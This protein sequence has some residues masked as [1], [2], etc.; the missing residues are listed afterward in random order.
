VHI[1]GGLANS[2]EMKKARA[3]GVS[4]EIKRPNCA[5]FAGSTVT[6]RYRVSSMED[7]DVA[8]QHFDIILM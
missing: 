5:T 7:W 6:P 1:F 8:A 3:S 4:Q 2:C